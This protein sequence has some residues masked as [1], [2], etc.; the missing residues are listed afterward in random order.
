MSLLLPR[1]R[2][3]PLAAH[4]A[5]A[6]I[7]LRTGA[8]A[9]ADLFQQSRTAEFPRYVTQPGKRAGE[10]SVTVVLYCL[11][12]RIRMHRKVI[13]SNPVER[14]GDVGEGGLAQL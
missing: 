1:R 3:Q 9:V 13:R 14:L 6:S 11:L 5:A 2:W 12:Q 10:V 7:R 4:L 8:D